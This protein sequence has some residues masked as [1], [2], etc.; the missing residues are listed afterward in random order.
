MASMTIHRAL[1]RSYQELHRCPRH[2][3]AS[4]KRFCVQI[5]TIMH[6][7]MVI[8]DGAVAIEI[9]K[10]CCR[11]C[12]RYEEKRSETK[13]NKQTKIN[14]FVLIPEYNILWRNLCRMECTCN[15]Q[16]CDAKHIETSKIGRSGLG[17]RIWCTGKMTLIF[18]RV[19]FAY[20][21]ELRWN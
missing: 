8:K 21:M 5:S 4:C 16:K 18:F 2:R 3:R 14:N 15:V 17:S 20:F 12:F 6:R 10:W 19:L 7:A 1:N 9:C 11:V 13:K